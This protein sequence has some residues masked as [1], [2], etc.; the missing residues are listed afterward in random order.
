VAV[1]DAHTTT[2]VGVAYTAI[3]GD[4]STPAGLLAGLGGADLVRGRGSYL[5]RLVTPVAKVVQAAR[6]NRRQRPGADGP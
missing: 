4:P 5:V 1:S 2:E 3:E 6:G